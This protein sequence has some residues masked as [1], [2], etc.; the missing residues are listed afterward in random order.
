MTNSWEVT[1]RFYRRAWGVCVGEVPREEFLRELAEAA[2][3][4]TIPQAWNGDFREELSRFADRVTE[5]SR[6][7]QSANWLG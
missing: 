2:R 7:V 5:G 3:N 6:A 1:L 4:G